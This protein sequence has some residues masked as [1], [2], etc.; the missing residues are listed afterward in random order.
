MH[1]HWQEVFNTQKR[2]FHFKE[3]PLNRNLADFT[4]KFYPLTGCWPNVTLGLIDL[5][6]KYEKLYL[7]MKNTYF[8]N[9]NHDSH[10]LCPILKTYFPFCVSVGTHVYPLLTLSAPTS[11]IQCIMQMHQN[12]VYF[13]ANEV[14]LCNEVI[15]YYCD[16]YWDGDE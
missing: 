4:A 11:G 9:P 14:I 12:A 16:Q 6:W 5:K 7:F 10:V 2:I 13:Y 3:T 8:L 1:D 15:N